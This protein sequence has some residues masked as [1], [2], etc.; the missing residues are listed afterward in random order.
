MRLRSDGLVLSIQLMT[1]S[2]HA[3]RFDVDQ[4]LIRHLLD[5]IPYKKVDMELP[6]VPK[7]EPRPK[8]VTET[9]GSRS[10]ITSDQGGTVLTEERTSA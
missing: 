7:P 3:T 6:K 1:R 5:S 2:W 9:R 10:P 4:T 8:G